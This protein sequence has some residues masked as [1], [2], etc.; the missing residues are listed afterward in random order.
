[1]APRFP[2]GLYLEPPLVPLFTMNAHINLQPDEVITPC[3]G[4]CTVGA[5]NLCIGCLRTTDE[6]GNWLNL[7]PQDRSRIMA[8]RS[9][10]LE[11]LFS[12]Q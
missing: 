8:E 1:V 7:T 6:I 5:A 10:R 4:V 12:R 11:S 3:I 9:T 2:A